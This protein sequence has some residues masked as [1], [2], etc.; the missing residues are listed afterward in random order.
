M[1]LTEAPRGA[2]GHWIDIADS[3]IVSK[4]DNDVGMLRLDEP[5]QEEQ[6]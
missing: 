2:L 3:K 6:T 1:G 4:D 5:W